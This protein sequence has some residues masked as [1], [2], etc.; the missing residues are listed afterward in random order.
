MTHSKEARCKTMTNCLLIK[1]E[2]SLK[3][4]MMVSAICKKKDPMNDKK[5]LCSIVRPPS[6]LKSILS[7]L[8][9]DTIID[10]ITTVA[11]QK[12]H[13]YSSCFLVGK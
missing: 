3:K 8:N 11:N 7:K 2:E 12:D 5:C 4:K 9:L 10:V 6:F 13:H 1:E